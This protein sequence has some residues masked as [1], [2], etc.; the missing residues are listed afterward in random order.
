[1]AIESNHFRSYSTHP[2]GNVHATNMQAPDGDDDRS[3]TDSEITE[4]GEEEIPLYFT[5]RDGRL[6][7]SHGSSPYPLPVDTAEQ[8]VSAV[9][10]RLPMPDLL[11]HFQFGRSGTNVYANRESTDSMK[12]FVI[13]C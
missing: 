4:V 9:I 10:T 2:S 11:C 7:H 3:D 6:F 12:S 1:M 5:E 13:S 8:D